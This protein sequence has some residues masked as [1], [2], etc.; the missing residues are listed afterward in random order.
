MVCLNQAPDLRIL[1]ETMC[2][3]LTDYVL[4]TAIFSYTYVPLC[5]ISLVNFTLKRQFETG[6]LGPV[7]KEG[8]RVTLASAL[9]L[10]S[11]QKIVWVDRYGNHMLETHE[12]DSAWQLVGVTFDMQDDLSNDLNHISVETFGRIKR[13]LLCLYT[14][15]KSVRV[16]ETYSRHRE[17]FT[18][19]IKNTLQQDQEWLVLISTSPTLTVGDTLSM[20]TLEGPRNRWVNST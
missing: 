12:R 3:I 1:F 16:N 17:W 11:R 19:S 9:T 10:A 2:N 4:Y 20:V 5:N 6:D 13:A 14:N 7:Y 15:R 8:G 18:V